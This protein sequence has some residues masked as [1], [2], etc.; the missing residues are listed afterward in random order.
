MPDPVTA[1][2]RIVCWFSAGAA[3]AVATKLALARYP[4]AE[5]V[6]ARMH[7][8]E[9]DSDNDRFADDCAAWFGR[10]IM[11]LRS[12]EYASCED[13]WTRRRYMSGVAGAP[14][15]AEMKKAPRYAFER[16]WQPTGQVF[17][18]TV[19]ERHRATRLKQA[20]PTLGLLAPLIDAGLTKADCFAILHRAGIALPRVYLMGY[21]NAN[22]IGCVK[23]QSPRYWNRVR[24]THP[25]VFAVRAALSRELGARLV[26]QT[27][28]DRARLFLDELPADDDTNDGA[29]L[30]ECGILCALAEMEMQ[31]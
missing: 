12:T 22:C 5:I 19:E 10:P 4:D 3:S 30:A 25:E 16:E 26:K 8:A 1:P 11:A 29:P 24:K 2:T 28:G 31:A 9:E 6:I 13:V 17:G 15:T 14:C 21:E 18:F 20:E 27:S 23:A 7:V